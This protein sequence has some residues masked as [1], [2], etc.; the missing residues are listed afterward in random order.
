MKDLQKTQVEMEMGQ[1]QV[2]ILY[3][4]TRPVGLP[5]YPN[6]AHVIKEFFYGAQTR[7]VQAS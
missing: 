6:P 7:P 4:R 3:A 1:V 2:G 5:H